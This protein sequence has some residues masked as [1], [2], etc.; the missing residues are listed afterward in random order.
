M[1]IFI[2]NQKDKT[3][4][5]LQEPKPGCWI[6]MISPDE[7]E[8]RE[9]NRKCKVPLKFLRSGLDKDESPKIDEEKGAK[10]FLV[11]IPK[12]HPE[13]KMFKVGTIP[14]TIIKTKDYVITVCLKDNSILGKFKKNEVDEFFTVMKTRFI[15][16]LFNETSKHYVEYLDSI[17]E[18]IN[19]SEEK[20]SKA[21]ENKEILQLLNLQ[22]TLVYFNKAILG[23][24]RIFENIVSG[25]YLQIYEGDIELLDNTMMENRE[26]LEMVNVYED[27]LSNTISAYASM[28]SNNLNIVMKILAALTIIMAIPTVISSLYGMNMTLPFQEHT[29]AFSMVVLVSLGVMSMIYIIFKK[30]K[31]V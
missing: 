21:L 19:K 14:L 25:K 27:L 22:K 28:V 11:K 4:R 17:E 29:N 8:I 20:L 5:S 31:W 13:S 23:N 9:I 30:I 1:E 2:K 24:N 15:F 10:M 6:N 3:V 16:Q 12:S 26:S 18:K 7:K